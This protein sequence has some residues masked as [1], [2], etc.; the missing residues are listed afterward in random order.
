[1]SAIVLIAL[2]S[3]LAACASATRDNAVDARSPAVVAVAPEV[4]DACDR[5]H[6]II[7]STP[8][9]S[10]DRRDGSFHDE[11]FDRDFFGCVLDY[12]GTFSALTSDHDPSS[13][14]HDVLGRKGW[15]EM[16]D[17]SADGPD[18][19]R[20]AF[21]KGAVACFFEGRWDGGAAGDPDL[22]PQDWYK[23]FAGC[24]QAP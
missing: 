12:S 9:L 16:L 21:R 5:V 11:V 6:E 10:V 18:G 7:A 20:F 13:R 19:T 4:R 1:V 15:E 24:T 2:T 14:L 3:L 22:P 8:G 17:H 23:V